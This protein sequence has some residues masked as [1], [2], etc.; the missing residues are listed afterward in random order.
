MF[1]H[2][3]DAV[4]SAYRSLVA[5]LASPTKLACVP[6]IAIPRCMH[7]MDVGY[8]RRQFVQS[9]NVRNFPRMFASFGSLAIRGAHADIVPFR[10]QASLTPR[11]RRELSLEEQGQPLVYGLGRVCNYRC[12]DAYRIP[13]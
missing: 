9:N 12:R 6:E 2:N 13:L 8:H 7:R 5:S 4:E 3:A 1:P 11:G 10:L